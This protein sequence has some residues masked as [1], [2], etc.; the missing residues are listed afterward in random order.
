VVAEAGTDFAIGGQSHFVAALAE[1][2][3]RERA[4]EAY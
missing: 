1:V 2:K 4:D 3:V